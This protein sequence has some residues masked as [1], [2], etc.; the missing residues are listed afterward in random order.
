ML[1]RLP[2]FD[3]NTESGADPHTSA[4]VSGEQCLFAFAHYRHGDLCTD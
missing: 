2:T 3:Q 1:Y 4:S